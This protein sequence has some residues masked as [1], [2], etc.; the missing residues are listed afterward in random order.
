MRPLDR[1]PLHVR[2]WYARRWAIHPEPCPKCAGRRV[3]ALWMTEAGM[4]WRLPCSTCTPPPSALVAERYMLKDSPLVLVALE[5]PALA[6]EYGLEVELHLR[7]GLRLRADDLA[8][9]GESFRNLGSARLDWARHPPRSWALHRTQEG[10]VVA[11]WDPFYRDGVPAT[12]R[13]T[14]L[15]VARLERKCFGCS[16]MFEVGEQAF[17][18]TCT[19]W[20]SRGKALRWC[21]ACVMRVPVWEAPSEP[22]GIQ[23][24]PLTVF[25]G[26]AKDRSQ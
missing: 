14:V 11:P 24:G 15:R 20:S 17:A 8:Y 10:S 13:P 9:I 6:S 26:D 3:V 22:Q 5:V 1:Y 19:N 23:H 21:S 25:D 4:S 18:P 12:L 7:H 16:R 2:D